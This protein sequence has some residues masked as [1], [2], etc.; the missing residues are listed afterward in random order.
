M[1]DNVDVDLHSMRFRAEL[2]VVI[3]RFFHKPSPILEYI[4][5]LIDTKFPNIEKQVAKGSATNEERE[6]IMD[7]HNKGGTLRDGDIL[8]LKNAVKRDNVLKNLEGKTVEFT[9][10]EYDLGYNEWEKEE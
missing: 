2:R 10:N 6:L 9:T 8:D 3:L 1:L 7:V 4:L 5:T